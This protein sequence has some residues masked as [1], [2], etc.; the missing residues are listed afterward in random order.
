MTDEANFDGQTGAPISAK[1]RA[2]AVLWVTNYKHEHPWRYRWHRMGRTRRRLQ[3]D[4]VMA[5]W[6]ALRESQRQYFAKMVP[7]SGDHE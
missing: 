1:G 4:A 2:L 5:K 6:F 3:E 7:R